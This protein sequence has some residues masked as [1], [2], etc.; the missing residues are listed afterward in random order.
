[1]A[2][3]KMLSDAGIRAAI[4][5]AKKTGRQVWKSDGAIPK[6]HGGLQLFVHPHGAPRWYWRSTKPDG[7]K[8]RLPMGAHTFGKGD[9]KSTFTLAQARNKVAALAALYLAPESRDV[10]AHL[11]REAAREAAEREAAER[12]KRAALAADA[13]AGEY[14]LE[15]LFAAYVAHLR[16]QGKSSA[17]AAE[18]M[19]KLHVAEAHPITAALPANAV[20][21]RDIVTLLRTL[22]EAGKGRTAGK[23]RSYLRAAYALAARAALD[24]DAPAAFLPFNVEA[25]PVQATA[26]L[27]Q[28]NRAL[29]RALS[30]PELREY[31][32]ALQ[33]APDSP[34]RDALLLLLLLGGQRPAQLARATVADVDL[35]AKT[36]RLH[37]PKGK[38]TQPRVHTLPLSAAAV[39]VVERCLARAE[40]QKVA[41]PEAHTHGW[42]F[43]TH[44]AAPLRPETLTEATREIAAALMA[45]PKAQRIVREVF[46][47]RDIR[48]TC[49]TRLAALGVSKDVRAQ[50]QSHG[51]GG[52]QAR[53]YDRHDYMPEKAAALAAWA[54]YL[55]TAP[56]DNVAHIGE[57]RTRRGRR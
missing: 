40:A 16:R 24:S 54:K 50:I 33:A 11:D 13:A 53:H 20:S 35:H 37:D 2:A 36:L 8:P 14:T 7:T 57:R 49:E 29:D 25:N 46:Q 42:L 9:G 12:T 45:K 52:I 31:W 10:R 56:A 41:R 17:S 23:L 22:T 4:A 32:A 27:A 5:R 1:M 26:A 55:A 39:P 6:T 47:L 34:A 48:R 19:F 15:K 18:G 38:R 28:Y 21:A 51:L 30:D 3:G 44:G 43:S